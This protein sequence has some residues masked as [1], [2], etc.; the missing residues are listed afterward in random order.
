MCIG[1]VGKF[2]DRLLFE[3]RLSLFLYSFERLKCSWVAWG[4]LIFG[5]CWVK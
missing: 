2:M 4:V 3:D 5:I 1:R